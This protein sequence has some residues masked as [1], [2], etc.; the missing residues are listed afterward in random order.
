M[1]STLVK[2]QRSLSQAKGQKVPGSSVG[3]PAQ[4][5][6]SSRK[7]KRAWRK[8]VDLEEVEEGLEEARA[9]ERVAGGIVKDKTNDQ[10]F[11]IDVKGDE[12]V[13]KSLPRF[14][15]SLLTSAKILAQRSAFPAVFSR[16][17]TTVAAGVKRKLTH[18]EKGRL[19]RMGKRVRRG[20]FNAM[21]DP[22]EFGS[23]SAMLEVSEA[24]RKSGGYDVWDEELA[25]G[26]KVKHPNTPHPRSHIT[27][28]A[29][30]TPHEGTSYNPLVTSHQE[31]LRTAH[32]IEERRLKDAEALE[33][34]KAK[35]LGG[36]VEAGA[37]AED[38]APGMTVD[39]H[40]EE[41]SD[42]DGSEAEPRLPAKMPRRKTKQERRKAE[43]RL[44][45]QRALT[46][47]AA[48]KRM[49]TS[50]DSAKALRKAMGRKLA[51]RQRLREQ[52]QAALREKLAKG[53]G[54]QKLGKHKVPEGN[55]DVQLGEDLTESL[56][57]LKPEGNLFRDRFLSMQHRALIEP[58]VP[59]LPK[60]R[61]IKV[62][63]YEK[64]AFK[65]FDREH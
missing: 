19:L 51:T 55:V 52:R 43:R 22:T 5:N 58:R 60:K 37:D 64:H 24:A 42:Q 26:T 50:I 49:L 41:H 23:G 11:L 40:A 46:E 65:R 1:A 31:L 30:P 56:R 36:L 9:E 17:T 18:E 38:V 12:R 15:T 8:N 10:L 16:T 57:A 7:G 54:G 6:Q 63:E 35:V 3:A 32:E 39:E 28:S 44:A 53:L 45:E 14:S 2:S 61:K 21:I 62:K 34:A 27:L 47:K 48:K 29:V 59:V 4:R 33:A 13:R 25:E 20:P